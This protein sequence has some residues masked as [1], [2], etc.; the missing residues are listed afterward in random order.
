MESRA[1]LSPEIIFFLLHFPF[2]SLLLNIQLTFCIMYRLPTGC[3]EMRQIK[4]NQL[5]LYAR[6]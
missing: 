5:K 4:I 1:D 2:P 3:L 6:V